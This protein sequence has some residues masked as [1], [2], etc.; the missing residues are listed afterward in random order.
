MLGV[1]L[2]PLEGNPAGKVFGLV[3]EPLRTADFDRAFVEFFVGFLARLIQRAHPR[4][5]KDSDVRK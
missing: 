3:A 1:A 2:E 5:R 4:L